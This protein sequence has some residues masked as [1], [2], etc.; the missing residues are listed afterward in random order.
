LGQAHGWDIDRLA[1]T[2]SRRAILHAIASASLTSIFA[3]V[4]RAAPAGAP[5]GGALP[6]TTLGPLSLEALASL[7][8]QSGGRL[9]VSVIDGSGAERA[10]HRG[11]ERFPMCSTFKVLAVAAVLARV[12]RGQE[13]LERSL[14]FTPV[15]LLEYAPVVRARAAER[16]LS[17][18]QAC[19]AAIT[20]SDNTAA[21]LLLE[22]L[23]GPARLTAF[24]RTLGDTRT[25][26]DRDEPSLNECLPGDER[27]TTTPRAMA[28]TLH[29]LLLG[30]AL[31]KAS[32]DRLAS[33]MIACS[34]GRQ[35]LRAGVPSSWRA[36][37]KTGTGHAGTTNDIA[38][39]WPPEG[40]P[41]VIATYLTQTSASA[42]ARNAVFAELARRVTTP[43]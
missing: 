21:N 17:V 1:M 6:A 2:S 14:E 40:K 41:L 43:A 8:R 7:E 19:E 12:D 39:L 34:T 37:D 32:R 10:R 5:P 30:P 20:L 22:S 31:S 4:S 9:G 35:R 28:R 23:G 33:W 29:A 13:R 15:D 11:D 25:R 38:I 27:D 42:D 3:G 16:Q 18:A 24:V 26:L 36:G